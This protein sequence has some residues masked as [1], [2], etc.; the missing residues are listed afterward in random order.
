MAKVAPK[1]SLMVGRLLKNEKIKL[2]LLFLLWRVVLLSVVLL[3]PG[4]GYDTSSTLLLE[5]PKDP[6]DSTLS[7]EYSPALKFL[8][9]DAVYFSEQ[10]RRGYLFE[11][12]WAFGPGFPYIVNRAR[13][14]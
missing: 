3:A 12:E 8:R 7:T 9:W 6:E 5:Y 1:D 13:G 11:Q 10:S 2:I 14:L 4:P